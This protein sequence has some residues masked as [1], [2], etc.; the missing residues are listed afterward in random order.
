MSIALPSAEAA[1]SNV[2]IARLAADGRKWELLPTEF[3]DGLAVAQT[4]RLGDFALVKNIALPACPSAAAPAAGEIIVDDLDSGFQQLR[5][6]W[7]T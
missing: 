4:D 5:S 2:A 7:Q 1:A 3:K 6:R